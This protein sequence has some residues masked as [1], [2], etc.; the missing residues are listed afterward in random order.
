MVSDNEPMARYL[1]ANFIG[2]LPSFAGTPAFP[3]TAYLPAQ[4]VSASGDPRSRYCERVVAPGLEVELVWEGLGRPVALE[5]SP[6]ETGT[7]EHLGFT[8]LVEARE[9]AIR[10]NGRPLP[11]RPMP[12]VQAGIETTTAFLYFSETWLWPAQ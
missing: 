9:A 3:G 2:K 10:V 8:V 7:K 4:Q 12:R 1:M 5:L 6:H 11:G